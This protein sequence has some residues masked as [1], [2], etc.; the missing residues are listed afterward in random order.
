MEE[1]KS[2]IRRRN[3]SNRIRRKYKE[4]ECRHLLGLAWHK[5]RSIDT[6]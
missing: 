4:K 2:K 1:E 5:A 6:Q 3:K